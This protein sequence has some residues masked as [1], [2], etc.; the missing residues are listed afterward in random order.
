MDSQQTQNWPLPMQKDASIFRENNFSVN[1]SADG[2][3]HRPPYEPPTQTAA[4]D[5]N[6]AFT[7]LHLSKYS[8]SLPT[9]DECLAHL[10][11]LSAFQVLKEDVGYT[12]GLFELWDARCEKLDEK[13]RAKALASIHEKRW[14]LYIARAVDRFQD[15][16]AK[17]LCSGKHRLE[18]KDMLTDHGPF[19]R[20]TEVQ[21]P[22]SWRMD[23]LPPLGESKLA[24]S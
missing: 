18:W 14:A 6:A 20:F 17:V 10:K 5:L 13:D 11:L 4:E 12:D 2:N 3:D 19:A 7:S 15:W 24:R 21:S 8:S 22:V 9:T 23:M 16:W 1:E